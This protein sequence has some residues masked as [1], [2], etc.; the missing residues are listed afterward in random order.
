LVQWRGSTG[1]WQ[2]LATASIGNPQA[3]FTQSVTPPA[4]GQLRIAWLPP[5]GP[6]LLSRSVS[7]TVW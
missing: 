1:A 2:T 7:V 5:K 6:V 4:S 3:Y